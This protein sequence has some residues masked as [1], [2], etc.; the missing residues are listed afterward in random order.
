MSSSFPLP[1]ASP[2]SV[3][4]RIESASNC[5]GS[6][7]HQPLFNEDGSLHYVAPHSHLVERHVNATRCYAVFCDLP[8]LP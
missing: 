5:D 8:V 3:S 7:C 6:L 4:L 2:V 1:T